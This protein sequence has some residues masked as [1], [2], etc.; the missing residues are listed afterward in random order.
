MIIGLVGFI[1]CGKGTVADIL[2]RDYG[3]QK[4]SFADALKDAVAIL[5]GWPR[6][7][8]EG[9]TDESRLF[10][11][12]PDAFWSKKFGY[13]VTPRH[14]LQRFGTEAMRDV[15]NKDIWVHT[16]ERR[17]QGLENVV[18]PDTRFENEIQ[19]IRNTGGKMIWVKRGIMPNA[20]EVAKMHIS[21]RAWLGQGVDNVIHN[22]GTFTD[23]NQE[24]KSVLTFHSKQGMI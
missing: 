11:E 2:V 20:E 9:D 7:L 16:L 17:I 5:F 18:V 8:L 15:M 23:L 10:R 4:F 6:N 19:F 12:T 1:G 22:D 3:Y 13:T 21:E 24:V 14:I